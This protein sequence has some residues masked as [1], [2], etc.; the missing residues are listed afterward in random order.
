[1]LI[2]NGYILFFN[3]YDKFFSKI[4]GCVIYT[5]LFCI[6]KRVHQEENLAGE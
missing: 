6:M 4:F 1:M 5:I 3:I 2:I